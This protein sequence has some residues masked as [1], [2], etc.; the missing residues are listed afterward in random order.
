MNKET[1]VIETVGDMMDTLAEFNR[2]MPIKGTWECT[3][4][5]I[6]VY[7]GATPK[8]N[9]TVTW[10][11]TIMVD[12]DEGYYRKRSTSMTPKSENEKTP[13]LVGKG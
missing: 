13:S 9:G 11:R 1:K 8:L 4:K 6:R 2:G 12:C 7:P 3:V 10:T 5:D